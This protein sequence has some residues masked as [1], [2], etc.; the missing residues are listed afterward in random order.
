MGSGHRSLTLDLR[1]CMLRPMS[2]G[3][4]GWLLLFITSSFSGCSC[5]SEAMSQ[6]MEKC[7]EYS[8]RKSQ[9]AGPDAKI[10]KKDLGRM[11]DECEAECKALHAESEEEEKAGDKPEE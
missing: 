9:C 4:A 11:Y 7:D 6:C 5:E 1:L 3:R 2:L 10:C 8:D